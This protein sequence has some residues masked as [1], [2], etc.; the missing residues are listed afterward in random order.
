MRLS[1]R[2]LMTLGGATALSTALPEFQK[3]RTQA[4]N[5]IFCVSDGMAA[6]IPTMADHFQQL[7][8]GKPSYWSWLMK[9]EFTVNGLQD[10]RSLNSIVTDSS[11]ASSA[12]GCGRHVW[13]GQVNMFPD[14]TELRTLTQ[15]MNQ[16]GI[17][18]G[19]VTTA[20][21]THATPA[22]FSVNC[23]F[24]DKEAIIAE[25]YLSNSGVDI[26]MGGGDR[27][28]SASGRADKR[29][30]YADYQQS[31]FKVVRDRASTLG[32]KSSKILGIYSSSHM[33][34]TV[35]HVNDP[36][37]VASTPTLAEMASVAID[38]LKD[39]RH[40]F[41]LQIEGAKIDHGCH[42]NDLAAAIYD[43]IAFEQAVKVA[44]DFALK[45]GNTLVVITADHATG[46]PSLNGAGTEYIDSP[47]GLRLLA[48]MKSSYG[49]VFTAMGTT[50]T[51][52]SVQSAVE[53]KLGI[54]LTPEEAQCV[55]DSRG[56]KHPLGENIFMRSSNAT[57]AQMLGNHTKVGWT[58]GN[59]TS[60]YVLVSA[61]G[62]GKE[63]FS[64]LTQN[65]AMFDIMLG[66]KGLKWRNP[67]MSFEEARKHM[68]RKKQAVVS[69]DEFC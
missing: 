66:L 40:G 45:D 63:L 15:I 30:L 19:L 5:I 47:A 37:L 27:F 58:G 44:I 10:C 48:A 59:H 4:K 31:G 42:A 36:A 22:G 11:A 21:I 64:G 55:V 34:F 53:E 54:K 46:G 68:E 28:F 9:Q 24:R 2:D 23:E 3:G 12:W 35:D 20:T 51:V 65:T 6:S 41:L 8:L 1:R 56:G 32:L 49:S 50:P 18:C 13:N 60:D 25:R 57:L 61:V 69:R 67:T 38:N 17:R 29:D 16:A 7:E 43:Q 33:P 26:L 14:G 62:P 52:A 39:S